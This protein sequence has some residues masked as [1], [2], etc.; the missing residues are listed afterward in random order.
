MADTDLEA[1]TGALLVTRLG[2]RVFPVW[3]V[4]PSLLPDHLFQCRC[5]DEACPNAGKHPIEKGW[6]GLASVNQRRIEHWAKMYRG[7]NFGILGDDVHTVDVDVYHGASL[8]ALPEWLPKTNWVV[9]TGGGGWHLCYEPNGEPVANAKLQP[10][11]DLKANGGYVVA[12]GSLHVSGQ[13]YRWVSRPAS[14]SVMVPW[15]TGA[16]PSASGD[17][18]GTQAPADRSRLAPL[19]ASPAEPGGRND[20]LTAVAGHYAKAF[21]WRDVFDFH[22]AQANA[23][24]SE[25]LEPGELAKTSDSIWGAE[26]DKPGTTTE[27]DDVHFDDDV[28]KEMRRQSIRLEAARRLREDEAAPAIDGTAV[29]LEQLMASQ[30]EPLR[31][32]VDELLVEG[33]NALLSAQYKAGKT[34]MQRNL[35]K[36]LADGHSFLGKY[37]CEPLPDHATVAIWDLEMGLAQSRDWWVRMALEHPERVWPLH[38][39][40]LRV[41]LDRDNR[42]LVDWTVEWLASRKVWAWLIDPFARVFAGEEWDNPAAGRL[43]DAIDEIKDRSGVSIVCLAAHFGRKEHEPGS[44]HARG[45]TRLDDWADAR[46][47]LTR[48]EQDRFFAADGRDVEV[49]ES[50]IT[51]DH[52][53]LQMTI[54]EGNR[55]TRKGDQTEDAILAYIMEAAGNLKGTQLERAVSTRGIRAAVRGSKDLL[56]QSLERMVSRGQLV[57]QQKGVANLYLPAGTPVQEML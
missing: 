36:A 50:R 43:T 51:F 46:W 54:A 22:M 19:L 25:P 26:H 30:I 15:P 14:R 40:G 20:W 21:E 38:M 8:G 29:S 7:C 48:E 41:A 56:D 55:R 27:A 13:R 16:L 49:P 53:T 39:K 9:A 28:S 4:Q 17:A 1:A 23:S 47:I 11:V 10:G 44:E 37:K 5:G 57:V 34:T 35:V 18:P 32:A 31:F 6:Q 45:P 3:G 52:E 12:P 42:T 2:C 33:G 24:L